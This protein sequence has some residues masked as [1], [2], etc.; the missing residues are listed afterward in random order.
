MTTKNNAYAPD[1][2]E[3]DNNAD[4]VN[5][6][7]A[8]GLEMKASN[9]D[10]AKDEA[11]KSDRECA[12]YE[13]EEIERMMINQMIIMMVSIQREALNLFSPLHNL[14][15][16]APSNPAILLVKMF[17]RMNWLRIQWW[18]NPIIKNQSKLYLMLLTGTYLQLK[19]A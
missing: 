14:L 6:V 11:T 7:R 9:V 12:E 19:L 18:V 5:D 17:P 13:E 2:N 16:N 15:I 3:E 10:V 1:I 4:E 8:N